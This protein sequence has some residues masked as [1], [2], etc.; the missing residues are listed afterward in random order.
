M[1]KVAAKLHACGVYATIGLGQHRRM[2]TK[3]LARELH[4]Q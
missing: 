3:A 4:Q 1:Y 2:A